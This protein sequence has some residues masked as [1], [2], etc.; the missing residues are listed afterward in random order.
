MEAGARLA[1]L[2]APDKGG[3]VAY[4]EN[5][6][7]TVRYYSG[8]KLCTDP[9]LSTLSHSELTECV[10]GEATNIIYRKADLAKVEARFS[11]EPLAQHEALVYA[12]IEQDSLSPQK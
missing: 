10:Q 8:L 3:I 12:R 4:P 1:R 9:V 7:M 6:E 2:A 5:L 11:L